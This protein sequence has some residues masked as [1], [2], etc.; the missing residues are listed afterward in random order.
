MDDAPDF[1][2]IMGEETESSTT[3]ESTT[4]TDEKSDQMHIKG[5]FGTK[6][7]R[8]DDGCQVCRGKADAV[9]LTDVVEGEVNPDYDRVIPVCDSH[10]ADVRGDL[11]YGPNLVQRR[12]F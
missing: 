10:E 1:E 7:V 11:M 6:T 9:L 2:D 5:R 8:R 4:T 3:S 12:D